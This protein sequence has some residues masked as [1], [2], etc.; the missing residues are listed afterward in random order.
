MGD[1]L[2]LCFSK[3]HYCWDCFG[4]RQICISVYTHT[5]THTHTHTTHTDDKLTDKLTNKL[6]GVLMM[7]V[8]SV[9]SPK[10]PIVSCKASSA[11][12]ADKPAPRP[13][14]LG[15]CQA[16]CYMPHLSAAI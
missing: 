6:I 13:G 10:T 7:V 14:R 1:L 15:G 11:H 2:H 9:V 12:C 4:N 5:H 8:E 3:L 16:N